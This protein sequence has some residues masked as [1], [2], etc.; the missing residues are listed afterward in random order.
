MHGRVHQFHPTAMHKSLVLLIAGTAAALAEPNSLTPAQQ[1]DAY[2]GKGIAAE[3]A[4]DVAAA[5]AAYTQALQLNPGLA[6]C[7][8]RLTQLQIDAPSIAAKGREAK[9]SKVMVP[10]LQLENATL[11]EAID[12]LSLIIEKEAK[13]QLAANFVIQDPGKKLAAAKITLNLKNLPA[14]AVMSYLMTQANAKVRY[15]EHAVVIE[16]K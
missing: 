8:Y 2:Y 6:N 15:D 10:A 12:G 9:F 3:K 13:G 14:S 5:R 11:Q 1:A 7:R 4:G 16:P